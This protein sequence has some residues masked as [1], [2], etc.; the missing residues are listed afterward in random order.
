LLLRSSSNDPENQEL[1]AVALKI[2]AVASRPLSI[3]ELAWAV[4]LA[5]ARD[6]IKTV[7]DLAQLVDH[8]RVMSLI[9]PF[10]TRTDFADIEKR[11]VQLV[12]QSVREFTI[13]KWA[14]RHGSTTSSTLNQSITQYN[15]KYLEAFILDICVKY[16]LLAE[17]GSSPLFSEEQLAIDELPQDVDLFS[18]RASFEYDPHCAWESWE[19]N[20]IHYD[21]TERGF[22]GF[23]VYA[24]SDWVKHFGAIESDLLPSLEDIESLCQAGSTRL[25][26]WINQNCRPDCTIKT[27]FEFYG[28]LY[29]PLSITSLYGSDPTLR[30]MLNDSNFDKDKYLD[31]SAIA[32][33]DQIMQWGE[34]SKIRIVFLEGKLSPQLRTLDFIR[35]VVRQWS[36]IG[37][38]H[39]DWE[40]AFDLV[41]YVMDTLVEEQWGSELLCI[42]ARAGC[43]PMV[44]RL[45]N[46]AQ[47]NVELR[48]ELLRGFQAVGEAVLGN[49]YRVVEHILEEKGFEAHLQYLNSNGES[50]LHLALGPC[51]PAIFRLL[52][53][54]LRTSIH[55][56]DSH[57]DIALMRIIKNIINSENRYES[58]KVILSYTNTSENGHIGDRQHIPLQLAMEVGDTEM[59]RLLIS[60]GKMDP[61]SALK[62]DDKGQRVL[63][64]K[65]GVNEEAILH[66]L[67]ERASM[68]S[69]L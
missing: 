41:D 68:A 26:N 36:N 28:H 52:V 15:I 67:I 11:Q 65:P 9:H 45:L 16:L 30:H 24:S 10:I 12:H 3:Q 63:K 44:E 48:T 49:S 43:M 66:L 53:P 50:V 2:L 38:R 60:E 42:A 37:R 21:P 23:F 35:L 18:D 13:R 32:A 20:M 1:A 6:K 59:C 34:L 4:A 7:A 22:G 54:R 46:Q 47:H 56:A 27:R 25:Y 5:A 51:N 58:A 40:V 69:K 57:G 17:I 14:P 33:V 61:L 19:E 39:D 55:R 8:Q 62:R 29:D 64:S 31:S